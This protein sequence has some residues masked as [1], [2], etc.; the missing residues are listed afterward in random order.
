MATNNS[1]QKT[2]Q[3]NIIKNQKK[4][5]SLYADSSFLNRIIQGQYAEK[6][7]ENLVGKE[8]FIFI[9]KDVTTANIQFFGTHK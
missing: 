2:I 9:Y 3:K 6:E 5:Q 1:V 8:F 7:L 4:I